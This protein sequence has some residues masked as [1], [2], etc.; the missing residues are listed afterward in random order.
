MDPSRLGAPSEHGDEVLSIFTPAK[1]PSCRAGLSVAVSPEGIDVALTYE[2]M[3]PRWSARSLSWANGGAF[4][5]ASIECLGV[6]MVRRDGM[7]V[8][9]GPELARCEH[10]GFDPSGERLLVDFT[11]FPR[12]HVSSRALGVWM[13]RS[14]EVLRLA[15]SDVPF[16]PP[17]LSRSRSTS[18]AIGWHR[19]GEHVI[20][21]KSDVLSRSSMTVWSLRNGSVRTEAFPTVER[22]RVWLEPGGDRMLWE[23]N[24]GPQCRLVLVRIDPVSRSLVPSPLG[25]IVRERP[26]DVYD[27]VWEP[28]G[29][30]L[31]A[32]MQNERG[33]ID[34]P[35]MPYGLLRV[36]STM[37]VRTDR[38]PLEPELCPNKPTPC[39]LFQMPG[40]DVV[41][42]TDRAYTLDGTNLR[43]KGVLPTNMLGGEAFRF[44]PTGEVVAI[45]GSTDIHIASLT[46]DERTSLRAALG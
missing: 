11:P 1:C 18:D 40:G 32:Y 2:P 41:F 39:T 44:D 22:G 45:A 9:L 3:H 7:K 10:H 31:I 5:V 21:V 24:S 25:M 42:V 43:A 34:Y 28:D 23:E 30:L 4:A 46:T 17:M 15:S 14:G 38:F 33:L 26:T 6:T 8:T 37:R 35:R 19:S 27:V 36:D 20:V 13:P 12:K 29:S 16:E